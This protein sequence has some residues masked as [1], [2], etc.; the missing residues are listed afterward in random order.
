MKLHPL[1]IPT[2]PKIDGFEELAEFCEV[3]RD[4]LY[5]DV[6]VELKRDDVKIRH[7]RC[8]FHIDEETEAVDELETLFPEDAELESA[9]YTAK[10]FAVNAANDFEVVIKSKEVL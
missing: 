8:I 5:E 6:A 4:S 10:V 3:I 9:N 1:N 7:S 2:F